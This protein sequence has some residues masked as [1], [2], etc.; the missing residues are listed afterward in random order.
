M[1]SII[2]RVTTAPAT[3]RVTITQ[4]VPGATGATGATGP[5]GEQ[6]IQGE[7]GPQGEVGPQGEQGPQGEI[8][9]TGATGATG[10]AGDSAYDVAVAEGFVGDEAAWLASLVGPTGPTGPTGPAGP[11]GTIDLSTA[12]ATGILPVAKGGTGLNGSAATGVLKLNAGT[13]SIS[14]VSNGDVATGAAIAFSKLQTMTP[15][16]VLVGSVG[17][18]P[19]QMTLSGD[20]TVSS[21]GVTAIGAGVIVN[22]DISGSAAIARSKLA[23]EVVA[24]KTAAYT[25]VAS[26]DL[27]LCDASGGAFTITLP[28]AVGISGKILVIKKTDSTL[29]N[30]VT[31]DGSGSETIDGFTTRKLCTQHEA[32]RIVSDGTNWQIL[33]RRIPGTWTSYTPAYSSGFGTTTTNFSEWRRVGASVELRGRGTTGTVTAAVM[34][35]GLPSGI[36]GRVAGAD[37]ILLGTF[38]TSYTGGTQAGMVPLLFSADGGTVFRVGLNNNPRSGLDSLNANTVL[39]NGSVIAWTAVIP[40]TDWEG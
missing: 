3:R 37:C 21:A 1:S 14:E 34:Q 27:I 4:G 33:D 20:V 8:G 35:I 7:Q 28:T 25:A 12:S 15:G 30:H 2:I 6:G 32:L 11:S 10:P 22:A 23:Y 9:A 40:V 39:A 26:D 38:T 24:S 13:P 17:S 31:I 5:Q 16:A 36:V 19:T 29:A 18:V